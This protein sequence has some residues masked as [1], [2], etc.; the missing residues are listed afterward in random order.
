M[1]GILSIQSSVAYGHAGN[2]A[3]VF[4]LQRLGFE[5]WPVM[6]VL[7]SNHTGYG[8]WG[9]RSVDIEWVREVIQ[10]IEE[11]GAFATCRAVLSGYLGAPESG[12]VVL[13]AVERVRRASID[14][15]YTCDPVMGDQGRG[16][17]VRAGIPEFFR[18]RAVPAAHIVTPN[19]FE[20]AYLAGRSISNLAEAV[21]AAS[22]I[23]KS[24]PEIVVVTSLELPGERDTL[25]I[26][27]HTAEASWLVQTPRLPLDMHGTGDAFTALYLASY[28]KQR[29]ARSSLEH[30]SSAMY[31]LVAATHR[32]DSHELLLIEAQDQ[33]VSPGRIFAATQ[34]V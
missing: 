18:D 7:F 1:E 13:D 9:G 14:S 32:A 23:R 26:L 28:L 10:G 33:L 6:T 22:L 34:V 27:A 19:Q 17:F 31:G 29:D 2:S 3:A 21:E 4:P 12:Q 25:G 15:I 8:S 30:A 11:R 16:F 5:V 20:L 24:G